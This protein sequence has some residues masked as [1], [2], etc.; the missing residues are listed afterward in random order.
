MKLTWPLLLAPV[1][2]GIACGGADHASPFTPSFPS[3]SGGRRGASGGEGGV[4]APP[5]GGETSGGSGALGGEG[6]VPLGGEPQGGAG[7]DP[8]DTCPSDGILPPATV[9]FA[10]PPPEGFE[11][12]VPQPLATG[13]GWLIGITP[14]EMVAVWGNYG[15]AGARYYIAERGTTAYGFGEK[16][17]LTTT[18][19]PLALSADGLRLTLVTPDG[20]TLR[21][22]T[23][24]AAG[25]DF[26]AEGEGPYAELNDALAL[27][28]DLL[29]AITLSPDDLH[30][31]YVIYDGMLG[32]S[33]MRVGARSSS[34][35]PFGAGEDLSACETDGEE[36]VGRSP[37]SFSPDS[38]T[39]F[40]YDDLRR[41]ARAAYR[42]TTNGP[43]KWFV[44]VPTEHYVTVNAD[45]SRAYLSAAERNDA[46]LAVEISK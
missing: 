19:L 24:N 39:L 14:D 6:G 29:T 33:K 25:E 21:E 18:S 32:K 17:L 11:P 13:S 36:N 41:T 4:V 10:C 5:L 45:C 28:G 26:G 16:V 1:L 42:E 22:A 23:R 3:S 43:F 2:A 27:G 34:A 9:S 38:L 20:T 31:A 30:V 7:P 46:V 8:V 35:E 44:D 40:Y 15:P 12:L 37:A